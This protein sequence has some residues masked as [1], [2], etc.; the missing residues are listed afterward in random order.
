[1]DIWAWVQSRYWTLTEDG[2]DEL[3]EMMYSMP[4]YA[5]DDKMD[6]VDQTFNAAIPLCK[7]IDDKWLE[8][9]FRHWRLQGHVLKNYNAKG[10]LPEAIAL[11][12]FAHTEEVKD[13]PQRICAVQDLAACYGIKDGPGYAEE[14]ISVCRETLAEIDGSWPCYQCVGGELIEALMDGGKYD[15]LGEEIDHLQAELLAKSSDTNPELIFSRTKYH[16]AKEEYEKAWEIV[17]DAVNAEGGDGFK[18]MQVLLST[19]TLCHLGRWDEA[20]AMAP[21]FDEVLIAS[22][23]FRYWTQIQM[24]FVDQGLVENT[25]ELRYKF[26]LL[27]ENLVEKDA[28]RVAFNIYERLIDLCC[29]SDESYRAELVLKKMESLRQRFNRDLGAKETLNE[30]AD[31]VQAIETKKSL[32]AFDTPDAL[33]EFNFPT[34]TARLR[35][36]ELGRQTWPEDIRLLTAKTDIMEACFEHEAAFAELEA[37]YNK[38]PM[39]SRL[40]ERFGSAYLRKHGFDE[41]ADKFPLDNLD[42]LPESIIWNRGFQHVMHHEKNNPEAALGILKLIEKYW[43][44]DVWLMGRIANMHVRL[45]DFKPVADYRKRQIAAEPDQPNHKWDLLIAATLSGDTKTICDMGKALDIELDDEGHYPENH[46]VSMRL[47]MPIAEGSDGFWGA[48]RLGP[49]LTKI[50]YMSNMEDDEQFYGREVVFDPS[51]LNQ[52]DQKDEEGY[53]C[54]KDGFY[55]YLYPP[56]LHTLFDPKFTTYA[57]DGLHP[58]NEALARLETLVTEAGFVFRRRSGEQYK[59]SWTHA[60]EDRLDDGIYIYILVKDSGEKRLNKL[61]LAFNETLEHPLIWPELAEFLKDENLL[62]RQADISEKYCI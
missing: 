57:V 49:A 59:L 25:Q 51:P 60:D 41:Y 37:A 45:K 58:G 21:S 56:P 33:L 14:R 43:S 46:Q 27:A 29:R 55:N 42:E 12:D 23:Y 28:L 61:L 6:L 3:A 32:K 17:K 10:L 24:M 11:L 52:L 50:T 34:E 19:L 48:R 26:H 8:L 1:M 40:E 22:K 13:C 5:V 15:E 16:L 62:K 53:V 2:H 54:D 20:L 18:R 36:V 31:K 44:E 39:S 47:E 7:S 35:S 9:F 4:G 30:L 38:N